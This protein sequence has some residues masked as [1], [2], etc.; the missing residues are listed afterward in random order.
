[1][2]DNCDIRTNSGELKQGVTGS[3]TSPIHMSITRPL[4]LGLAILV[5]TTSMLMAVSASFERGG[6]LI[7]RALLVSLSVSICLAVHLIPAVSK[8]KLAWSLWVGCLLCAL[9]SHMTFL[10]SASGHAGEVRAH[11]SAQMVAVQ[12]QIDSVSSALREI[13]ARPVT[14]VAHDLS[15]SNPYR[16]RSALRTEL[17]ESKR[18]AALRDELIRLNSQVA[19]LQRIDSVDPVTALLV[20]VTGSSESKIRVLI[21]ATFSILLELLGALLWFE[22]LNRKAEVSMLE[23]NEYLMIDTSAEL[24]KAIKMGECKPTVSGIRDYLQCGQQKALILRR[25]LAN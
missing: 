19:T 3:S 7:E 22:L 13:K 2:A 9:Y 4:L 15:N 14:E 8:S 20:S 11:D 12:R 18:A 21:L 5:T 24:K 23:S 16:M 6:S 10:T 25:S 1:M 17:S